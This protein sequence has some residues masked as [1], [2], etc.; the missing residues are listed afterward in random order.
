M[1]IFRLLPCPPAPTASA[2]AV[3][4]RLFFPPPPHLKWGAIVLNCLCRDKANFGARKRQ[5]DREGESRRQRIQRR[6][7]GREAESEHFLGGA[8]THFS[9]FRT[10]KADGRRRTLGRRTT[11]EGGGVDEFMAK[12]LACCV[13]AR[14]PASLHAHVSW[15]G[16]GGRQ[17]FATASSTHLGMD[18]HPK[19]A[20]LFLAYSVLLLK[21]MSKD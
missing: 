15:I 1:T 19:S 13:H 17:A 14:P 11:T 6:A 12:K 5:R 4:C 9:S 3:T 2:S 7:R 21:N 18:L 10:T 16:G 8:K 20:I